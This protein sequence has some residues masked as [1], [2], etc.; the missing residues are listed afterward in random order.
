MQTYSMTT[1]TNGSRI[2]LEVP[3]AAAGFS[4]I[5][6]LRLNTSDGETHVDLSLGDVLTLRDIFAEVYVKVSR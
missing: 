5:I 1:A 6:R 3:G 4:P 2:A